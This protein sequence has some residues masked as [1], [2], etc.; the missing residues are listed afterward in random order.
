M[1]LIIEMD[2][3]TVSFNMQIRITYRRRQT[4]IC[5]VPNLEIYIMTSLLTKFSYNKKTAIW[6]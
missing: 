1:N 5:Y 3:F 2:H 6:L 4:N